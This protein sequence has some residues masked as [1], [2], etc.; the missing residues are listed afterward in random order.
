MSST[1]IGASQRPFVGTFDELVLEQPLSKTAVVAGRA[2]SAGLVVVVAPLLV[3][4]A[5]GARLVAA[6]SGENRR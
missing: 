1:N 4:V 6:V 5:L 3:L 2:A